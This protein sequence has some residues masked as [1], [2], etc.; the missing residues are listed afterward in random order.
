MG[1]EYGGGG[2]GTGVCGEA[3]LASSCVALPLRPVTPTPGWITGTV[4]TPGRVTLVAYDAGTECSGRVPCVA[5]TE[6]PD[7]DTAP[8]F[9]GRLATEGEIPVVKSTNDVATPPTC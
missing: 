9:K 6:C 1:T 2:G 4:L 7:N 3:G 8:E 5:M